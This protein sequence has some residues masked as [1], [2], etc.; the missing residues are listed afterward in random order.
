MS[1]PAAAYFEGSRPE[2]AK[3]VPK[4]CNSILD[5]GCGFGGLG[6][7][8][9]SRGFSD[10]YGIEINPDATSKLQG[11]YSQYWIGDIE[12]LALPLP[13]GSLDCIIFADVLEHLVDPWVALHRYLR[14]LRSGGTVII[15]VPN[16][17]NVALLYRLLVKGR[18]DYEDAGLLDRTHLRFFTRYSVCTLVE[19]AGLEVDTWHPNRDQYAGVRKLLTSALKIFIDD[20]DICQHIVVAQKP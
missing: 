10:L 13:E 7:E 12:K 11:I 2:I 20:I 16:V 8:L 5:V 4:H 9:R 19:G 14:L 3:L 18:W 1:N 15:S 17:R 6:R